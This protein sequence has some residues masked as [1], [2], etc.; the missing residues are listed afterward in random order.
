MTSKQLIARKV[1]S[2][3]NPGDVVNLGIG[4]PTMVADYMPEGVWLHT[5][6]GLVGYGPTPEPGKEDDDYTGAGAQ[7]LS[8]LPGAASF[9][10]ALSFAIIRGG[11]LAATV[12]GA[13]EVDEKGNIANWSRP[14]RIVGMGGAMD[15]VNG[16]RKVIVAMEHTAKGN[17]KIVPECTLPLTG[18]GVVDLIVTELCLIEVTKEGLVLK[19]LAPNVTKDDVLAQTTA[20]LI[21][22][23]TIGVM[24]AL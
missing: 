11:H 3:L 1:A 13:L 9:D 22:P 6:N 2:M 5:E 21:I 10:S 16:A 8:V 19:E 15:L 7:Y 24:W 23:D 20:K 18:V 17:I 4:L 12:L 14:G